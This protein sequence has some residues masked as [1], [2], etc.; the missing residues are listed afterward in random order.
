MI[1]TIVKDNY[2]LSNYINATKTGYVIP[3]VANISV[4][5]NGGITN[6]VTNKVDV[7][8]PIPKEVVPTPDTKK[9]ISVS[10]M[11]FGL[12]LVAIGTIMLIMY[13]KKFNNKMEEK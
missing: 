10:L 5:D 4:K 1:P 7:V 8:V 6:K 13:K 2:D 9:T 12:V 3:N 11:V